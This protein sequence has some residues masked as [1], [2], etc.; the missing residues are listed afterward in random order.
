M[1][2]K[3]NEF[4]HKITGK[5]HKLIDISYESI[6]AQERNEPKKAYLELLAQPAIITLYTANEEID[7]QISTPELASTITLLRPKGIMAQVIK[8][9]NNPRKGA[10]INKKE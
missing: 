6:C 8:L 2:I 1:S 5:I 3:F 4:E 7:N 9:K 10:N